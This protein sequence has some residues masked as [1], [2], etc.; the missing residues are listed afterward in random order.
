MS[1]DFP[2][3]AWPLTGRSGQV[4]ELAGLLGQSS[5]AV[6]V[7]GEAGVGKTRLAEAVLAECA[8]GGGV[9][10]TAGGSTTTRDVPFL[11]T[12]D[13]FPGGAGPG[14]EA[15]PA[16]TDAV[17]SRAGGRRLV[18]GVDDADHLDTASSA[19]VGALVEDAGASV[20][21]TARD[22][23]ADTGA[24]D[25]LR[26]SVALKTVHLTA[27]PEAD[28]GT[29]LEH[30][31]GGPVDGLSAAALWRVTGGNPLFLRHLLGA[32]AET[33][34]LHRVRG[35]WGWRGPVGEHAR[36]RDLVARAVGV[37]AAEQVRALEYLAHAGPVER[38]VLEA[39][40]DP[41]VLDA[42]AE[43]GLITCAPE[44]TGR[45]APGDG[46]PAVDVG[47]PVTEDEGP[48]VA[49]N[50]DTAVAVDAGTAAAGEPQGQTPGSGLAGTETPDAQGP[51]RMSVSSPPASPPA[52]VGLKHPLYGEVV[53]AGTG[54]LRARRVHRDLAEALER[55]GG[56]ADPIRPVLWRQRAGAPVPSAA[57]VEAAGAALARGDAPLA[58]RL[59][60]AA[61]GPDAVRVQG[62]ALVAQGLAA[63]AEDL[64]AAHDGP[65]ALRALNLFWGL[66]RPDRARAV[67]G[68]ARDGGP[69][70]DVATTALALFTHGESPAH[71]IVPSALH[72]GTGGGWLVDNASAPL[73]A[74]TLTF[75]GRPAQV[76]SEF[77]RGA[78]RL[79]G[80]WGSMRGAT[81]ACQVYALVMAGRLDR[82]LTAAARHYRQAVER[83]DRAEV[84]LVAFIHGVAYC[85]AGRPAEGLPL[86]REAYAMVNDQTI[87]PVE[88][89][90]V[91]EYA[92]CAAALGR[93]DVAAD[94]L[95]RA[96]R[97]LPPD[98]SL[99]EHLM[100][101]EARVEAAAGRFGLAADLADRLADRYLAG[102]RLTTAA[103]SSY[104]CCRLRPTPAAARRLTEAAASCDS[105][106]F[107]L[108]ARHGS[109]LAGRDVGELA[110]VGDEL[111][112][113][114]YSGLALEAVLAASVWA[115]GRE[116]RAELAR[117]AEELNSRCTGQRPP[118]LP[119]AARG[120]ALTGRE[121]EVCELAATGMSNQDV[122]DRL[123][124][125]VRTVANLLQRSYEK[126]SIGRRTDLPRALALPPL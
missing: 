99:R 104:L 72:T 78:I 110:L 21:L 92:S 84:T 126:L 28:F 29:L 94:V 67:L 117:L 20:L 97:H 93:T 41:P 86:L 17:R 65:P 122:A 70:Y 7:T 103:E 96:V 80:A 56:R 11:A 47:P 90:I 16:L 95:T 79:P 68:D 98:S 10:L 114:G 22:P 107:T 31:L 73:R 118:W 87:F 125:S 4:A 9:V 82:A 83:G 38:R 76:V 61:D 13:W 119:G 44:D 111:G 23:V 116:R 37:L 33:G 60:S 14:G 89:Y 109:A 91:T 15:L 63:R 35:V 51:G 100:K 62:Q 108:F 105:P 113:L 64:L 66:R 40:V 59:A 52:L 18:L 36:L 57:L 32:G 5:T 19:L 24:L 77:D 8:A 3:G 120:G 49:A 12:A 58:E 30:V 27:L 39:L 46:G 88:T 34:A 2:T 1:S 48:V 42:L 106:L 85:W 53:R 6:L 50:A 102:G 75:R 101:G 43:R 71:R 124:I 121:R 74:Y 45:A 26:R 55:Y 69:E 54:P 25:A 81:I 123:Q 115:T 112:R